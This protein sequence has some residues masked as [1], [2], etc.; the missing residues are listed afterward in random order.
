M[1]A[2]WDIWATSAMASSVGTEHATNYEFIDLA[3]N[4]QLALNPICHS[5]SSP[6]G[7]CFGFVSCCIFCHDESD[8]LYYISWV[9]KVFHQL[10]LHEQ[11]PMLQSVMSL[12]LHVSA[13]DLHPAQ[14]LQI[15]NSSAFYW[16]IGFND[17][18]S[19]TTL[20]NTRVND[21][22]QKQALSSVTDAS[23][24]LLF[25][26][27]PLIEKTHHQSLLTLLNYPT[28]AL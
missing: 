11:E 27:A 23:W 2:W 1:V 16:K 22:L 26:M 10:L 25:S 6:S 18:Q 24:P 8:S 13:W 7:C 20:R 12:H 19:K 5:L 21:L 3:P 15:R 28:P 17:F 4:R 9:L 14:C